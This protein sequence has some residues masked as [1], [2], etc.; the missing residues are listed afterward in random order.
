MNQGPISNPI[1]QTVTSR[2][3]KYE[4]PSASLIWTW[5]EVKLQTP[6]MS[7]NLSKPQFP[8]EGKQVKISYLSASLLQGF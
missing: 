6:D 3:S 1:L 8:C 7:L 5:I 2:V 4:K